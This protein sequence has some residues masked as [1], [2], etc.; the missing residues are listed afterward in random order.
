MTTKELS[1]SALFSLAYSLH[2]ES[3][4]GGS[5]RAVGRARALAE[6][7]GQQDEAVRMRFWEGT[8]LHCAGRFTEALATLAPLLAT[9]SGADTNWGYMA[10]GRYLLIA[11]ELPLPLSKLDRALRE[12]S[13]RIE[14]SHGPSRQS[15][16][17][18]VRARLERSRGRRRE[19]LGLAQESL[20]HRR[21]E[22][23]AFTYTSHYRSIVALTNELGDHDLSRYYLAEWDR[24]A[25]DHGTYKRLMI[26]ALWSDLHLK[27]RNVGRAIDWVRRLAQIAPV[28][29]DLGCQYVAASAQVRCWVRT[30]QPW[31]AR[32]PLGAL[33]GLRTCAAG[34]LRYSVRVLLGDYHLAVARQVMGLP[35]ID[36]RTGAEMP[37][38]RIPGSTITARR[39]LYRA[40]RAYH[41]ASSI[42]DALDT[43]LECDWRRREVQARLDL[44]ADATK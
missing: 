20:V 39:S 27:E 44:V 23:L 1:V 13:E 37:V 11:V 7:A 14:A 12:A 9:G 18:L 35:V 21:G 32:E 40:R 33:L 3:Q 5:A 29:D 36:P 8:A 24:A 41:W 19:A 42:G 30:N 43:L 4:Q 15:R 17:L 16:L 6:Q 25:D 38:E 10:L 34:G 2:S 22:G 26:A 28:F 31:R